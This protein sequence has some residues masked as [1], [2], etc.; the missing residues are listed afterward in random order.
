MHRFNTLLTKS[1]YFAKIKLIR[2]YLFLIICF[3]SLEANTLHL[4][5]LKFI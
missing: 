3:G 1:N 2:P 5:L 4:K